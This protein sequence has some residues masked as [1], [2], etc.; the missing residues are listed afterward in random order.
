MFH[1][2]QPIPVSNV[3]QEYDWIATH[4]PDHQKLSQRLV[5]QD[6]RPLD[7]FLLVSPAGEHIEI[8]FDISSFY[9]RKK[10]PGPPCPYCGEPLRTARA[11][12]CRHCR[13]SWRADPETS[14]APAT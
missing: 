5:M 4:Y 13:R 9:G 1:L 11:K 3:R 7:I 8:A 12:Q 6:G 14:G 10:V 2:H